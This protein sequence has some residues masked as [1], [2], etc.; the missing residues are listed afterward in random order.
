MKFIK[1]SIT[2]KEIISDISNRCGISPL[3]A[4]LLAIRNITKIEQVNS[5]LFGTEKDFLSPYIFPQM[6]NVVALIKKFISDNKSITIYG[7]YDCDGV[8]ATSII[9]LSLK[10]IGYT[11]N[12]YIPI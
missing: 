8:G 12:Y 4:E 7:D 1:K 2:N 10:D 5:F 3:L 11:V 6:E 9:Y